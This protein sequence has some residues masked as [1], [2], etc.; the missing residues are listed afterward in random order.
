MKRVLAV[1]LIVLLLAGRACASENDDSEEHW[2]TVTAN[3][4]NGRMNPSKGSIK[5][6]LFDRND[7]IELTGRWDD[8]HNWVEVHAGES[9]TCWVARQYVTERTEPF[10]VINMEYSKVRIRRTPSDKGRVSG[11]LRRGREVEITQVL[12]GW[13]KCRSGWIDLYYVQ[14]ED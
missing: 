8:N 3:L 6:A 9:G 11:Y 13:G 10:M 1:L 12:L 4:L 2:A 7:T 5:T 14:E